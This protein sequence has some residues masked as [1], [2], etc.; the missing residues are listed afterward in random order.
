MTF[1]DSFVA[2][3]LFDVRQ[4]LSFESELRVAP[5]ALHTR[6]EVLVHPDDVFDQVR[7]I[8]EG[9]VTSEAR[10]L[11]ALLSF[12]VTPSLGGVDVNVGVVV[13]VK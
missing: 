1:K 6:L 12:R 2:V 3:D 10:V 4:K 7:F 13:I 9:D 5:L 11:L 8:R